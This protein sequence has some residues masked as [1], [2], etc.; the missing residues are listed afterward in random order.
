MFGINYKVIKENPYDKAKLP[1]KG[2]LVKSKWKDSYARVIE[3]ENIKALFLNTEFKWMCDDY[4]FLS[5]IPKLRELH[6]LDSHASGIEAISAQ[7]QLDDLTLDIPDTY[8]I[9][10]TK[11]VTL[12]K[13][14]TYGKKKNDSLYQCTTLEDL[15]INEMKVGDRHELGNLVNLKKLSI[16]N[17]DITKLDFLSKLKQLEWLELIS[18]KK[19]SSFEPISNLKHLKRLHIN[20]YK[21]IGDISFL[22]ALES[23]EVLVIEAGKLKSIAPLA[24]LTELKALAIYGM[25][26]GIA[27]G[28][29]EPLLNLKKL[30]IVDIPS[31]KYYNYSIASHWNWDDVDKPRT[32]WLTKK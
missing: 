23:L 5:T 4:A 11:L 1:Y 17:S 18:C 13:L 28:N 14:F 6:I 7:D 9:D 30:G 31:R 16:A 21:D 25:T 20:E 22:E 24:G 26:S 2:L 32:N 8:S 12:K 10:Y 19:I 27:D 15:Y 29:L 3:S